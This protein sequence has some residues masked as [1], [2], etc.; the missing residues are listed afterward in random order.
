MLAKGTAIAFAKGCY[1]DNAGSNRFSYSL[2]RTTYLEHVFVQWIWTCM[3]PK[4]LGEAG[5]P[6][7]GASPTI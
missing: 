1:D 6:I 5:E 3:S 4:Q 7:Q 2:V